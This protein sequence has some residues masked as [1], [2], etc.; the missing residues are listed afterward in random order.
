M[1]ARLLTNP[2]PQS[3]RSDFFNELS[4]TFFIDFLF[5]FGSVGLPNPSI[6]TK[7]FVVLD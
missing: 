2:V 7:P 1:I 4:F 6:F 3:L 5:I